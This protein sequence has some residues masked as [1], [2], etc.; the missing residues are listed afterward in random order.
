MSDTHT[1]AHI[2]DEAVQAAFE[3]MNP[4][5]SPSECCLYDVKKGLEAAFPYLS[6]PCAVEVKR[7]EWEYIGKYGIEHRAKTSIG[8]YSCHI[9]E[10]S[11]AGRMFCYL[12]L[13]ED[14]DCTKYGEEIYFGYDDYEN[15]LAAAQADFEHRILSC[16]VTKPVDVAAVRKQAFEEA[17]RIADFGMMVPPD[18]GSPT[19]EEVDVAL[20]IAAAIRALSSAP[21]SEVGK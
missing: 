4:M 14:G 7:L 17:A 12:H 18:G 10:D 21:T 9:D 20:R 8:T 3:A 16:V 1:T 6:A 13:T 15:I 2:P 5:K 11:A 19:K